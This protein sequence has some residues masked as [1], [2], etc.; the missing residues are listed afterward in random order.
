MGGQRRELVL[1]HVANFSLGESLAYNGSHSV[2]SNWLYQGQQPH[3]VVQT[4]HPL[5]RLLV[6][7]CNEDRFTSTTAKS[8]ELTSSH[9]INHQSRTAEFYTGLVADRSAGLVVASLYVGLLTVI[10]V[11]PSTGSDG[12]KEKSRRLSTANQGKGKKKDKNH[13]TDDPMDVD[14]EQTNNAE[15]VISHIFDVK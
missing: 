4:D 15:L 5:A 9:V 7:R 10:Q 13:A 2:L 14:M 6:Y 3:I 11:E 8:L 12:Q 1:P